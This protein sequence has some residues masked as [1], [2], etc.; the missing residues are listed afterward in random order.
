LDSS[1][2]GIDESTF[3]DRRSFPTLFIMAAG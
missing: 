3:A 2:E 1:L